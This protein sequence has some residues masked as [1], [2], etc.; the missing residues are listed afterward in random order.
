VGSLTLIS[1]HGRYNNKI[2]LILTS[3][4]VIKYY[5][6]NNIRELIGQTF[7]II[8]SSKTDKCKNLCCFQITN[9]NLNFCLPKNSQNA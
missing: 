4:L 6:N 7:E 9:I 5:A 1:D 8:H 3:L 2:D